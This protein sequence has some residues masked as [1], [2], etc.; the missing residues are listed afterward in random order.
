MS[1]TILPFEGQTPRIDATAFVAPTACVIGDVEIG[2]DSSIWYGVTVRGD[3]NFIRIGARTNIQD[4]SVVHVTTA[5]HPTTIGDDVLIGHM[6]MI[7]GCALQDSCFIGM[8]ACI[9][10]GAVVESGA[11]IAAG[12]LIG[13]GKVVEAGT[14][15]AG[16]P[17]RRIRRLSD[18]DI[19]GFRR[20][21]DHYADLARRHRA[22]LDSP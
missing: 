17:G 13:P 11:M 8:K 1:P 18:D 21:T 15:W 20:G 14:L 4:N 22:M 2:P 5:R 7:H 3:V 12:A 10:D 16:V 6:A 19:A 9:L